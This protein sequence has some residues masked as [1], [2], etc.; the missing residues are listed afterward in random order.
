MEDLSHPDRWNFKQSPI[1]LSLVHLLDIVVSSHDSGF[2]VNTSKQ[3]TVAPFSHRFLSYPNC[4]SCSSLDDFH[5]AVAVRA[6]IE[7]RCCIA[8]HWHLY[9][10]MN[11][12][13]IQVL[14]CCRE[15]DR[16]IQTR[17]SCWSLL[18]LIRLFCVVEIVKLSPAVPSPFHSNSLNPRI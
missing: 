16:H 13:V 1:T 15:Q 11:A 6:R 3:K 18:V 17:A 5:A 9:E 2:P 7:I 4:Y 10:R 14:N 12:A 8:G